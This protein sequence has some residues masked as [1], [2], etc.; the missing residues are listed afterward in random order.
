[1]CPGASFPCTLCP[2]WCVSPR[3][4]AAELSPCSPC[5]RNRVFNVLVLR[6]EP[7]TTQHTTATKI[8]CRRV[9]FEISS[10]Y[11]GLSHNSDTSLSVGTW[12]APGRFNSTI[13][14]PLAGDKP[15]KNLGYLLQ[16]P[17]IERTLNSSHKRVLKKFLFSGELKQTLSTLP[18]PLGRSW[19]QQTHTET[20]EG[21]RWITA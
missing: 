13:Q 14:V 10:Y 1:M 18:I 4:R 9:N 16:Y 15:R 21:L 5:R 12:V 2:S 17:V 11:L 3:P 8:L 7:A 6:G 20:A 19:F